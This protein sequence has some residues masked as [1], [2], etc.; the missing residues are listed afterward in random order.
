MESRV[1]SAD[2]VEIHYETTGEGSAIILFVHGGATDRGP[3]FS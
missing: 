3:A 1:R 2:G